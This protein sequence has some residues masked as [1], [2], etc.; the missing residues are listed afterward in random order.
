MLSPGTTFSEQCQ[1]NY[2]YQNQEYT[3]PLHLP[4]CAEVLVRRTKEMQMQAV[5]KVKAA[6]N[7][8]SFSK[9]VEGMVERQ[10]KLMT[11]VVMVNSQVPSWL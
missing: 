9:N 2:V 5:A 1:F 7:P 10:A 11:L 8:H 4:S 3:N 6:Q